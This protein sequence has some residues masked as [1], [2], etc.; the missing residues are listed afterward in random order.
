L[1]HLRVRRRLFQSEPACA[2]KG[3]NFD[4]NRGRLLTAAPARSQAVDA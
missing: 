2:A 4:A 1:R 3:E